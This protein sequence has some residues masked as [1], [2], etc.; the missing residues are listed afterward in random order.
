MNCKLETFDSQALRSL[1]EK[2]SIY[3]LGRSVE[4]GIFLSFADIMLDKNEKRELRA[5]VIGKCW[6]CAAITKGNMRVVYQD[7]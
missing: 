7:F 6:G 3:I 1:P 2:K 5:S 4:R